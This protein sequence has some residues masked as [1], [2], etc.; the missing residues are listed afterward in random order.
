MSGLSGFDLLLCM[1]YL[2]ITLQTMTMLNTCTWRYLPRRYNVVGQSP[3]DNKHI[4]INIQR[5]Q[6]SG[7]D[8]VTVVVLWQDNVT[9]HANTGSRCLA[10]ANTILLTAEI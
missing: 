2:Q 4:C 9:E 7:P 6:L 1:L 5:P 3:A 8:N 10:A